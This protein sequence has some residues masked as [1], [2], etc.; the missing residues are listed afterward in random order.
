MSNIYPESFMQA[1]ADE[2]DVDAF[3]DAC[4]QLKIAPLEAIAKL[5]EL[6]AKGSALSMLYIG[7][8]YE[9]GRGVERN[10]ELGDQWYRKAADRGSVEAAHRLAFAY[11]HRHEYGKAIEELSKLSE[12]GFTPAMFCLGSMY[13]VGKGVKPSVENAMKYWKMAEARGH[14]LAKQR[15]SKL[16]RSGEVG[17]IRRITGYIKLIM[18]IIPALRYHINYPKSDQLRDW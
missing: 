9:N 17:F 8:S 1:L 4:D 2:P 13:Y 10:V 15:L 18:L 16:F 6:A 12:R 11:W 14:L 5:E 7:D 3:W